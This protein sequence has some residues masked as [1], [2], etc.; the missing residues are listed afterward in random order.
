MWACLESLRHRISINARFSS[1]VTQVGVGLRGLCARGGIRKM[2]VDLGDST[3]RIRI[4]ISASS[5]GSMV[6]GENARAIMRQFEGFEIEAELLDRISVGDDGGIGSHDA[7]EAG[8]TLDT[9]GFE[10]VGKQGGGVIGAVPPKRR[11]ASVFGLADE[12]CVNGDL[13]PHCCERSRNRS[14]L[15]ALLTSAAPKLSSVT[16]HVRASTSVASKP[17]ARSKRASRRAL[18]RSPKDI[19]R[20]RD[21][22]VFWRRRLIPSKY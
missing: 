10:E 9:F 14:R 13:V 22:R 5:S 21:C 15:I 7:R 3:F 19:T 20:S 8:P 4:G 16:S 2:Q 6:R 12:S 11:D 18:R 1:E 17:S